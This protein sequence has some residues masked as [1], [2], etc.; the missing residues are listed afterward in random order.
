MSSTE[1]ASLSLDSEATMEV[2]ACDASSDHSMDDQ[3]EASP[4]EDK[5][6]FIEASCSEKDDETLRATR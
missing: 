5:L 4:P 3:D 6:F 1:A 2:D